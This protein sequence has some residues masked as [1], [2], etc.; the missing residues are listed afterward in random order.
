MKSDRSWQ[1]NH[2]HFKC[3]SDWTFTHSLMDHFYYFIWSKQWEEM[4]KNWKEKQ[5]KTTNTSREMHTHASPHFPRSSSFSSSPL[6]HLIGCY[7]L[8]TTMYG[9][10]RHT[11][12]YEPS[13]RSF[14]RN[15]HRSE[16]NLDWIT[17][18]QSLR[19]VPSFS[20]ARSNRWVRNGCLSHTL[21]CR[22]VIHSLTNSCSTTTSQ[23]GS[24]S[25]LCC[26]MHTC[27]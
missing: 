24:R 15:K 14:C 7:V 6:S 16:I 26:Y 4:R 19:I 5:K 1:S 23:T 18:W 17:K 3:T 22:C 27:L 10:E 25:C 11:T 13:S 12:C 21:L 9:A 2:S 20:A 8:D